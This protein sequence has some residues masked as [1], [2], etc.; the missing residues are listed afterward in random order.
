MLQAY[1]FLNIQND[2]VHFLSH[3]NIGKC[4]IQLLEFLFKV[5]V[6]LCASE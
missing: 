6:V 5:K 2:V 1:L 4:S 3:Y